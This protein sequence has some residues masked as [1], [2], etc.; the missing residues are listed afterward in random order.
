MVQKLTR[1]TRRLRRRDALLALGVLAAFGAACGPGNSD[2]QSPPRDIV[3]NLGGEVATLKDL[4]ARPQ[5]IGARPA[6][7][8]SADAYRLASPRQM[9]SGDVVGIRDGGVVA[10]QPD[11]PSRAVLLGQASAWFPSSDG[12]QLWAVTEEPAETACAGQQVPKSVSARFTVHKYETTGRPARTTLALA[13][14]LQPIADTSRGLL[15]MRTTGD[16]ET[17]STGARAVTDIVLLNSRGDAA[18][19]TIATNASVVS[20]SSQRVIWRNDTCS[21][22]NCTY[23]YEVDPKKS[24]PVPSC[25][26]GDTV[27]VGTL[28]PS[29]RWYVTA[30]R[31]N[32]LAILDLDENTC[33][34]LDTPPEQDSSNSDLG[35]TFTTTWAGPNLL[36]LD[37]RTG[38]LASINAAT[39]TSDQRTDPLPVT[40]QAQFWS[41]NVD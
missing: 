4:E 36:L 18:T 1:N 12:K 8:D 33:R 28:D 24:I 27:G 3:L 11:K 23:A 29:G 5:V 13:C 7:A 31:A 10:I 2:S 25:K 40:N 17:T 16:A 38:T 15:A 19:E 20:A 21:K 35:E 14:G 26:A 22:S 34:D 32:R 39:G 6:G 41:A 9:A 37:Q 30:L